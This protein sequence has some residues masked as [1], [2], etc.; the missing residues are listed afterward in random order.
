MTAEISK[1][2]LW[3]PEMLRWN[4]VKLNKETTAKLKTHVS[5]YVFVY[6]ALSTKKQY[7]NK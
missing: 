6:R 3:I 7:V 5:A 1:P 4:H 2:K